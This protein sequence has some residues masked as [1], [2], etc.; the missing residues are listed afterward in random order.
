MQVLQKV[1]SQQ[2]PIR[3]MTTWF[4]NRAGLIASLGS[5]EGIAAHRSVRSLEAACSHRHLPNSAR[6]RFPLTPHVHEPTCGGT[7][8]APAIPSPPPRHLRAAYSLAP[9]DAGSTIAPVTAP[10]SVLCLH[11]WATCMARMRVGGT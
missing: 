7:G 6:C 1:K 5:R 8:T 11:A 4:R 9:A 2:G 3:G 10:A